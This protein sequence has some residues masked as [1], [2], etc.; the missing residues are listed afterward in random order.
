MCGGRGLAGGRGVS[1]SGN[2]AGGGRCRV[3]CGL[4][5]DGADEVVGGSAGTRPMTTS[6]T[7]S[8]R[9]IRLCGARSGRWARSAVSGECGGRGVARGGIAPMKSWEVV[10]A[11]ALWRHPGRF[12]GARCLWGARSGRWARGECVGGEDWPAGEVCRRRANVAGGGRC[13][14]R[15]GP[16]RDSADEV[17]GG[18]AGTRPMA[19]S[20]TLSQ[21]AIR[22]CGAR[23]GRRGGG[24][25]PRGGGCG[26]R[27]KGHRDL[28]S[29][30]HVNCPLVAMGSA[31][32]WP[33]GLPGQVSGVTPLPVR[34][35]VRR[36]DSPLVWHR[37]A[38]C[39][40]RSTV[41][42]ARV[43]GMSS[44]KPAGWRL[45]LTATERFS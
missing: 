37:W 1:A 44:S 28:P 33:P 20:R 13:R 41:A 32:W 6:R 43:L 45:E 39:M 14:A 23:S 18:S 19:T 16:R 11:R 29:G 24:C 17:V 34:A 22:L 15:C 38:W 12:P 4:R 25:G 31:R 27:V 26:P 36:T 30:G 42:V 2:V 7:L 3:G 35:W 10:L 40:S 5:R 21:R 9:A 8:R